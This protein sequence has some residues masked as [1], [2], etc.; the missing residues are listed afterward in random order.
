MRL[1]DL[2]RIPPP[3]P[4]AKKPCMACKAFA[5]EC[6]VP[7]GDGAVPMC[8]LCAHH[9]IDHEVPLHLAHSAECECAPQAVYPH[10]ADEEPQL[11]S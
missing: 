11:P 8:W 1:D 4:V 5:A 7:I 9:V 10:R 3:K 6:L 2:E